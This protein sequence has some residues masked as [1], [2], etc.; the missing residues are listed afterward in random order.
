[1]APGAARGS[2]T[3]CNI[4]SKSTA[5]GAE[6]SPPVEP[7][8]PPPPAAEGGATA[9]CNAESKITPMGAGRAARGGGVWPCQRCGFETNWR[10]R[11]RCYRCG[12]G[13]GG[14]PA[15]APY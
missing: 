9:E 13:R 15:C 1:M 7:P 5:M 6:D 11:R 4:E 14:A 2:P 10:A 3:E 12:A 8:Q